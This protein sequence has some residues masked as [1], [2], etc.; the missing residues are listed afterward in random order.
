MR[1]KSSPSPTRT[2]L[3]LNRQIVEVNLDEVP[4]LISKFLSVINEEAQ[5]I[6]NL[7]PEDRTPQD[8][9]TCVKCLTAL[10]SLHKDIREES[11]TIRQEIRML[12]QPQVRQ[13]MQSTLYPNGSYPPRKTD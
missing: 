1:K 6:T 5:R 12:P 4:D 2:H 9:N 7:Q 10:T 13:L 3:T 11:R 8:I